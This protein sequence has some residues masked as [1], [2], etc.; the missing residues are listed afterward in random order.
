MR[1]NSVSVRYRFFFRK[2]SIEKPRKCRI[3][4]EGTII[5][6]VSQ[7]RGR[8]L[9]LSAQQKTVWGFCP[10]AHIASLHRAH[11][12]YGEQPVSLHNGKNRA[13]T[14]H[15]ILFFVTIVFLVSRIFSIFGGNQQSACTGMGMC[16][17][18][19]FGCGNSSR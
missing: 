15:F 19:F 7:Q 9:F 8:S 5:R 16:I 11:N 4:L 6:R 12:Q 3:V 17:R 18:Q 14:G 2:T 1:K 13:I 10:F